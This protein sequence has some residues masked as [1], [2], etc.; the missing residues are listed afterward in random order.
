[1]AGMDRP[2]RELVDSLPMGRSIA[3]DSSPLTP[4]SYEVPASMGLRDFR[5]G[6][7]MDSGMTSLTIPRFAL[8]N[9]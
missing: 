9:I 2:A 3:G 4:S 7:S 8:T 5:G 6:L 1:M